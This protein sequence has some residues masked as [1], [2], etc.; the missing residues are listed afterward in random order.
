MKS[1]HSLTSKREIYALA[2]AP[3][4]ITRPQP[5]ALPPRAVADAET[6]PVTT[7]SAEAAPDAEATLN[8]NQFNQTEP[9]TKSYVL[10]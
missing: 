7:P 2:I 10:D 3:S 8:S 4:P 9:S 1:M 5:L 6:T